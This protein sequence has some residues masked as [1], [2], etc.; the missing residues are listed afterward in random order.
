[1]ERGATV[2][3]S[4]VTRL[5]LAAVAVSAVAFGVAGRADAAA[6]PLVITNCSNHDAPG[7]EIDVPG[8]YV[9][10]KAVTNC[11][12]NG[13]IDIHTSNV[14]LDLAGRLVDGDTSNR[15]FECIVANV[16]PLVNVKVMNGTVSDCITGV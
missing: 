13:I 11:V 10:A 6:T 15:P 5:S 7:V 12:A 14:T 1:M 16:F 2:G 4:F 9:L 3:R 8:T